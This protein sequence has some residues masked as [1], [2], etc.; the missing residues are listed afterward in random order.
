[1]DILINI[2]KKTVTLVTAFV[3][4]CGLMSGIALRPT[5][6]FADPNQTEENLNELQTKIEQSANNYNAAIS[7]VSEIE[8][9]IAENT[10]RITE[11]EAAIP[12]QQE[13]GASATIALYKFHNEGTNLLTLVLG[14]TNLNEFI[15]SIE[16]IERIQETN[17]NEL[18]RLKNMEAELEITQAS[19][20]TSRSQAIEEASRAETALVEAQAVR[21]EAQKK[22]LAQTQQVQSASTSSSSSSSSSSTPSAPSG[23]STPIDWSVD[24]T[25]FVNQWE[26]RINNYLAGSPLAGQGRS[27][28]EAAWNYGVDPRWSPAIANTESSKGLY[29]FLPYNAWGWGSVSWNS[30]EQAI[31][32]HVRGLSRGYGYTIS[33]PA[34]QKYC[35]SWEHWY[36]STLAQMNT[37]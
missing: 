14:S 18:L 29:C 27:F 6:A 2:G 30:W 33:I 32:A 13:K 21:E 37:I 22:A 31:D 4:C 34:A 3:L 8:Q 36:N 7:K 11:L 1:M 16:Y 15:S 23:T 5:P 19:L 26:G 35:S 24:K 12:S 25:A 20:K 9:R 10:A 28:A 17:I